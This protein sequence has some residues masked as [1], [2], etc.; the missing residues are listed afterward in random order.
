VRRLDHVVLNV[1][2]YAVLRPEEGLQVYTFKGAQYIR[3][4]SEIVIH[5]RLIADESDAR[6]AYKSNLGLTKPL[7]PKYGSFTQLIISL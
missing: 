1:A 3:G 5:R 7:N 6:T 2:A 4:M